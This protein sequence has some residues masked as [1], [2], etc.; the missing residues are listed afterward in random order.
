MRILVTCLILAS[1]AHIGAGAVYAQQ[2]TQAEEDLRDYRAVLDDSP[3]VSPRSA[4]MARAL[5]SH[6]DATDAAYYNPAGI[7]GLHHGKNRPQTFRQFYFMYGGGEVNENSRSMQED[8]SQ[9]SGASDPDMATAVLD[10]HAG[11]R[12]YARTSFFPNVGFGRFMLGPIYDVQLAA[13]PLGQQS[14][15]VDL[16]YQERQGLGF[17][18]SV[19]DAK[20]RLYLGAFATHLSIEDVQGEFLYSDMIDKQLRKEQ[21][22]QVSAKYSGL[23]TNVGM[24]WKIAKVATPTLSVAARN[25]GDSH[26]DQT[27]GETDRP[28]VFKQDLTVGFGVAPRLGKIGYFNFSAEAGNLTDEN[29]SVSKKW[30]SGAEFNFGGRGA[31]SPFAIRG[32][33]NNAGPSYGAHF[34]LGIL[35]LQYADFA[36]DVGYDNEREIERRQS[37]VFSV[38]LSR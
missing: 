20:E 9:G 21:F 37:V 12:A 22:D 13:V 8:L 4:G 31:Q 33:I 2:A 7:G 17:G 18:F 19:A 11:K 25:V 36:E 3:V 38:D 6:A 23:A 28:L 1:S 5:S 35:G 27:S 29:T 24:V 10:A 16:H 32:G 15:L 34:N 30:R 14:D 26:Y